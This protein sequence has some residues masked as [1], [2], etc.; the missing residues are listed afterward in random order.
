MN[1]SL[2]LTT[3]PRILALDF[4]Y[5]GFAFCLYE[6]DSVLLDW[7]LKYSAS[8]GLTGTFEEIQALC[9]AYEPEIVVLLDPSGM[10]TLRR[11]YYEPLLGQLETL[12][13]HYG[14]G[15]TLSYITRAQIYEAFQLPTKTDIARCIANLFPEDL[16][17]RLPPTRALGDTEDPRMNLFDAVSFALT[18]V[19]LQGAS[20]A[21][22]DT[23]Q[24][25]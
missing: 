7:G 14:K 19:L 20:T 18:Y 23:Q 13:T 21:S 17:H 4:W 11:R 25:T 12:C 8:Q 22:A 1:P 2:P 24:K 15:I 16:A 9:E 10:R 3:S 6:N 5:R